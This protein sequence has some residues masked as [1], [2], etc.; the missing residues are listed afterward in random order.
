VLRAA[1]IRSR[2]R[3]DSLLVARGVRVTGDIVPGRWHKRCFG[4]EMATRLREV[5][6]ARPTL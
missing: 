4:G 3:A 1:L 5:R 6:V 2:R